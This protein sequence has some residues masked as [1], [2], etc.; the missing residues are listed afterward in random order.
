MPGGGPG[1]ALPDDVPLFVNVARLVP[2]KAQ[3]L[4]VEAF[5][6]VR[7]RSCPT[8]SSPSPAPPGPGR[9]PRCSTPS[10]GTGVG[11]AVHAAGLPRPTPA[12]LVAAADVFAFSSISEGSPGAVVEAMALGTPVAAFAIPPV[13][14]LTDG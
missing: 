4:L 7:G 2:E 1:S 3:H 10:S 14:E 12:A 5:A 11:E 9:G 6:L 8:P 13:A